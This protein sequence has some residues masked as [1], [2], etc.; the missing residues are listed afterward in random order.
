MLDPKETCDVQGCE[1]NLPVLGCHMLKPHKRK[2]LQVT[3]LNVKD[4]FLGSMFQEHR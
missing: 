1:H 3:W 2:T 4:N